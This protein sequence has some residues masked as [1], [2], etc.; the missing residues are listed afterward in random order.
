MKNQITTKVRITILNKMFGSVE[1]FERRKTERYFPEYTSALEFCR[2]HNITAENVDAFAEMFI[3]PIVDY[4]SDREM[5]AF[6]I[7]IPCGKIDSDRTIKRSRRTGH[8]TARDLTLKDYLY[9]GMYSTI[10]KYT[11]EFR[12]DILKGN[13]TRAMEVRK[14]IFRLWKKDLYMRNGDFEFLTEL[15][16]AM[17]VPKIVPSLWKPKA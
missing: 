13:L 12:N 6:G 7:K 3:R 15:V 14:E 8:R 1:E 17:K 9:I 16:E 5:T 11:E 10:H 2:L 4:S